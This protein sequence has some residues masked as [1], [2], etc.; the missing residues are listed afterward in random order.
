MIKQLTR[1]DT[2][3]Q[4]SSSQSS[5]S[6][7]QFA[8]FTPAFIIVPRLPSLFLEAHS[9]TQPSQPWILYYKKLNKKKKAV[10]KFRDIPVGNFIIDMCYTQPLRTL[11]R[12]SLLA[13][14]LYSMNCLYRL[15]PATLQCLF[16]AY[17]PLGNDRL[18]PDLFRRH[19]V[20]S[21]QKPCFH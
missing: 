13:W 14:T 20:M 2:R 4:I 12:I 9:N 7:Y 5:A 6:L 1:N 10:E 15:T 3:L 8:S 11:K 21:K 19:A 16:M 18:F 17:V